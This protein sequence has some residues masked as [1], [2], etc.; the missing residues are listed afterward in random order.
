MRSALALLP[1]IAL[2]CASATQRAASDP[3]VASVPCAASDP[4]DLIG[5]WRESPHGF[6]IEIARQTGL[7]A[8]TSLEDAQGALPQPELIAEARPKADQPCEFAG[9][10]I[11]GG[12]RDPPARWG[13]DGGLRMRLESANIL[14]VQYLDSRYT[15]GW[16]YQRE[17]H[18][19]GRGS[20]ESRNPDDVV[21]RWRNADFGFVMEI[22]RFEDR[23]VEVEIADRRGP[24]PYP[25][26][27]AE[28]RADPSAACEFSGRH[29]WGEPREPQAARWGD[30]GGL[31]IRQLGM[32]ALFV[33]YLDSQYTGG[34]AYV[35]ER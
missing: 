8:V 1:L 6:V 32:D 28:F 13:D 26:V 17:S 23:Y 12:Q 3:R 29:R 31:R 21:G 24:L 20:C 2:S 30:E 10:H 14:F 4:D 5:V 18:P 22:G 34:W 25:V 7:Y 11:W 27:S 9:R 16:T 35:R 19:I 33:Q 15:G